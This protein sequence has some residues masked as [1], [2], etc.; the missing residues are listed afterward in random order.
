MDKSIHLFDLFF[1]DELFGFEIPDFG[2]KPD[3]E[4]R[5]IEMGDI[6]DTATAGNEPGPGFFGSIA[7]GADKPDSRYNYTT[8]HKCLLKNQIE[9][10]E[11]A[12]R[13]TAACCRRSG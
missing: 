2:G 8:L 10:P 5:R 12:L 9:P 13:A 6:I 3:G 4:F 11:Q 1:M 7:E